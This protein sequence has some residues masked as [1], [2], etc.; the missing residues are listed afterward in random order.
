[1]NVHA[2]KEERDWREG[3]KVGDPVLIRTR[4]ANGRVILSRAIVTKRTPKRFTI[5]AG[6]TF[7]VETGA[8]YGGRDHWAWTCC[9]APVNPDGAIAAEIL[10][11]Q[12]NQDAEDEARRQK[13]ALADAVCDRIRRLDMGKL[14]KAARWLGVKE[15]DK[16]S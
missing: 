10:A 6:P 4:G 1:M 7:T 11:R 8:R 13:I 12:A 15:A 2:S 9:S 16:C 14:E 3:L 5:S